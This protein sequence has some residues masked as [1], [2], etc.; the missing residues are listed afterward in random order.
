MS[1]TNESR[2]IL[3]M[4]QWFLSYKK[5][6][7]LSNTGITDWKNI[8]YSLLT[9]CFNAF[10]N[11]V[12]L[13]GF[14]SGLCLVGSSFKSKLDKKYDSK[15]SHCSNILSK[16]VSRRKHFVETSFSDFVIVK[17]HELS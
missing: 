3:Y 7:K 10:T 5:V 1:D 6:L 12:S 16:R 2:I 14:S 17:V 8:A 11:L 15:E 9:G 4:N 13:P